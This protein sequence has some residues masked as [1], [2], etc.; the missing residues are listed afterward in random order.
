MQQFTA[1]E[2]YWLLN[3]LDNDTAGFL[4][5]AKDKGIFETYKILQAK[6][7][8]NKYYVATLDGRVDIARTANKHPELLITHEWL[9][10]NQVKEIIDYGLWIMSL[11]QYEKDTLSQFFSS[12]HEWLVINYPIMHHTHDDIRMVAIRISKDVNKWRGEK[13]MVKTV[14]Y[15]VSYNEVKNTTLCLVAIHQ[16]IRHQIRV[17]ANSVGYAIVG[18]RL[19]GKQLDWELQLWSIGFSC[20]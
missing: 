1:A 19:Y 20:N 3:R 9:Q 11:S 6:Q 17:H 12:H 5:F 4:Y 15:P 2:E 14:I 10:G 7:R 13:H 16:W 18:D 8:V